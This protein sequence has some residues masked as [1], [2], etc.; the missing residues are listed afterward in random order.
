MEP[1]DGTVI[2]REAVSRFSTNYLFPYQRLIITNILEAA[3]GIAQDLVDVRTRQI[4]VL[5][6]GSGKSLCFQLPA[7]LLPGPSLVVYPLLSLLADQQRRIQETG[8]QCELLRGG[9]TP[10]ERRRI[11]RELSA[12]KV[13]LL[14]TSPEALATPG[15]IEIARRAGFIHAVIDEA[16]CISQ[17]GKSFRPA[18]LGLGEVIETLGIPL[19]TAFTATATTE[20]LDD[21]DTYLFSERGAHR[22]EAFPDRP[23]LRYHVVPCLSVK[24]ALYELLAG[25]MPVRTPDPTD[26]WRKGIPV[27]RPAIVFCRTRGECEG[28]A[29]M[30]RRRLNSSN[31]AFYHAGMTSEERHAIEDWFFG[32]E[33]AILCATTAYGLGIDKKNV[34]AVIHTEPHGSFCSYVQESGRGGRDRQI[35][36]AIMLLPFSSLPRSDAQGDAETGGLLAYALSGVCRRKTILRAFGRDS[37][38]CTCCDVCCGTHTPLSESDMSVI[39]AMAST[40]GRK[41]KSAHTQFLSDTGESTFLQCRAPGFGSLSHWSVEEV[42]EALDAVGSNVQKL[43]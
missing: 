41:S 19:I 25:G 12:G 17:W 27:P 29:R 31:I 40:K 14:L 18:Y 13:D 38:L 42:S 30:L 9:Q 32:A 11:R 20:I 23:E 1:I 43:L 3:A 36:E 4:A 21:I 10:K 15:G 6:T 8:L 37:D 24:R 7:A 5:P 28:T 26:V 39:A 2:D 22:I 34:R 16:H 35:A 33:N